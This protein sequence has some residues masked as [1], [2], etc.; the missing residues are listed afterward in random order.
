M[1]TILYAAPI[2]TYC[3]KVRIVLRLKQIPFDE[4][5]PPGGYGS[6]AY[7]DIVPMGSIPAL[8]DDAVTM[9]E[10]EAIIEYL[11]ER[12]PEPPLLPESAPQR[13]HARALARVHD[14][15]VEPQL[16]SLY[17]H[18]TPASRDEGAVEKFIAGFHQ[19]LGQFS[20]YA[21]PAPYA[22]GA[23]LSVADCAWP[24]TLLQARILFPVFGSQFDLPESLRAWH[25]RLCE[26]AAIQ[27]ELAPCQE[28]MRYWLRQTLAAA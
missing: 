26:H 16:R 7:R 21:K 22:A 19:R 6:D 4:Q 11:E 9:S 17:A 24:T 5:Y 15:W 28:A 3:A 20:Q 10:S 1:T 14:C 27:P 25:Q 23:A 12:Y 8:A 2:S 18:V 13:A